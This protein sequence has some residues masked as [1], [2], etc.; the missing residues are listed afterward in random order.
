[1]ILSE[2][3]AVAERNCQACT[4]ARGRDF[5]RTS[6][7]VNSPFLRGRVKEQMIREEQV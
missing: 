1:L 3:M 7:F 4:W 5:L 2:G 6:E